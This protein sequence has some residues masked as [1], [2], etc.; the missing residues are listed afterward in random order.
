MSLFG[1][2]EA[3]QG[4][5]HADKNFVAVADFARRRGDHELSLGVDHDSE[6][7]KFNVQSPPPRLEP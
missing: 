5:A 4:Q 2:G 1:D 6:G 7:S 3:K